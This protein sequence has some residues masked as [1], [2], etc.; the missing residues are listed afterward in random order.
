MTEILYFRERMKKNKKLNPISTVKLVL[1]FTLFSALM[2]CQ[3]HKKLVYFQ[4]GISTADSLNYQTQYTPS[5]KKDD[6]ISI[7]VTADDP[8]T[9]LPFNLDQ[10]NINPNIIELFKLLYFEKIDVNGKHE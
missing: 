10:K 6:L 4:D 1:L 9:A 5:L 7:S 2:S 3:T 8:A